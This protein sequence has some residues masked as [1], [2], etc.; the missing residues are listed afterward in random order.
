LIEAIKQG[1]HT[2]PLFSKIQKVPDQHKAFEVKDGLIW[3]KNRNREV[4]LCVP[5]VV[6]G[7]RTARGLILEQGHEV[8]GHFGPQRTAGPKMVL[9]AKTW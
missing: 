5:R 9:V 2:D 6:V 8:I 4:V 3:T 7:T 1:Y